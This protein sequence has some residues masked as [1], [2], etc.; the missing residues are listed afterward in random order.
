MDIFDV[1]KMRRSVRSFLDCPIDDE[2]IRKIIEAA[3][4]A[5]SGRNCQPW[6]FSIVND[7]EK[8]K[9]VSKLSKN[10]CWMRKARCL[11]T[12]YL[13]KQ[14]SYHFL[15]DVQSCGAAIQNM[16]LQAYSMKIGTCWVGDII[17]R[18]NEIKEIIGVVNGGL[19]LMGVIALGYSDLNNNAITRRELESFLV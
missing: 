3:I 6:K 14:L 10:F 16:M 4:C 17:D 9:L 11:I 19:E 12:V 7:I 8:I 5:P 18:G 2:S 15:K 1:I 13:D